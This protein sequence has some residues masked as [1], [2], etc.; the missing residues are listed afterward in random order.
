MTVEREIHDVPHLDYMGLPM[1][2][3]RGVGWA[4]LRDVDPVV[5]GDGYYYLTC[6]QDVLGA[7][8]N[9]GIYSSKSAFDILGNPLPLVP[10][11]F[12]PPEHTRFRRILQP[13]VS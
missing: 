1:A 2:T 6:R 5:F 12:D 11:A 9:P 7:L 8:R 10:L 4:T 3:D 13:F